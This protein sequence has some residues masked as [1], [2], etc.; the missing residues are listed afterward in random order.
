M[1]ITLLTM[2]WRTS[3][4]W[5]VNISGQERQNNTLRMPSPFQRKKLCCIY[6]ITKLSVILSASMTLG[7][8]HLL[9]EDVCLSGLQLTVKSSCDVSFVQMHQQTT[10][11]QAVVLVHKSL[12]SK[13]FLK[14]EG[15]I[16]RATAPIL[17]LLFVLIWMHFINWIKK[18][19]WQFEFWKQS[20]RILIC[21][22]HSTPV[23]RG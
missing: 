5:P 9:S 2:Q 11:H 12:N 7:D 6:T 10:S 1:D 13:Y 21:R 23:L 4:H 22:L 17:P 19:Q 14:F 8:R 15:V 3:P 20:R 16:S 18:W